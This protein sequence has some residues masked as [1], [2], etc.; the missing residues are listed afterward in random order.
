ML[1]SVNQ[2]ID[3]A[4][5]FSYFVLLSTLVMFLDSCLIYSE[6]IPIEEL[7]WSYAH[8][9]LS[10]GKILLFLCLFSLFMALVVPFLKSII[11]AF[12][13]A[14][15]TIEIFQA[16]PPEIR[17]SL[18][19]EAYSGDYVSMSKMQSFAIINNNNVAQSVVNE[20]RQEM[21]AQIDL[22]K[23]CFGFLVA[24]VLSLL[25][26]FSD[27]TSLAVK[28]FTFASDPDLFSFDVVKVLL[29]VF[30]YISMIYI[31]VIKGCCF[32]L[33]EMWNDRI[34]FPGNDIN[35]DK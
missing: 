30:V 8:S 33:S 29:L 10:F 14:L 24:T 22:E 32:Q 34:Y 31:G 11:S 21:K 28:M 27:A 16:Y 18:R 35:K 26:G 4:G 9:N 17:S 23:Y 3:K 25:V 12:A 6:G 19:R 7:S 13:I 20:K 1:S 5:N 2:A 15:P